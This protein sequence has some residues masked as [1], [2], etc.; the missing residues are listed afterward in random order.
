ME[1]LSSKNRGAKYLFCVKDVFTKYAWVK[2]LKNKEN[3]TVLYGLAEIVNECKHKSSKL[4]FHEEKELGKIYKVL[5]GNNKKSYLR[6]LN[7]LVNEYSN[8]YHRSIGKKVA[9][10]DNFALTKEI[11]SS[12]K[13]P[14]L[15][16]SDR[17]R[18]AKYKNLFSKT[19]T[20]FG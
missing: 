18:I 15:Q 3:K 10:A 6:Y 2:P 11:E 4:W 12:H 1:S 20:K 17:V 7:K 14:K 9:D 19:N 8:S 5:T 16:I 13:T